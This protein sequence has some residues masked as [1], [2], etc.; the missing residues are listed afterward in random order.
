MKYKFTYILLF[1]LILFVLSFNTQK[2]QIKDQIKLLTLETEFTAGEQIEFRFS[3]ESIISPNLYISNSYGSTLL[4]PK[5]ENNL[6]IYYIPETISTKSGIV[7]WKLINEDQNLSGRF[8]IRP[9]SSVHTIESY[10]GPPSIQAGETDFSM[11]VGIPTDELD[12]PVQ[13]STLVIIKTQF[14][15]SEVNSEVYTNHL[16]A[17]KNIYSPKQT[18]RILISSVSLGTA[19]KEF[20]INVLASVPTN[21]SISEHRNH[22]YADG[23]QIVTLSTSRILDDYENVIED[24]TF[25]EFYIT[26]K[27]GAILKTSGTSINGIATAKI[28]HPDHAEKWIVKAFIKGMAES[29]EITFGFEQLF[30]VFEV[31]FSEDNRTVTVGPLKSF[32]QQLIPDGFNVSLSVYRDQYLI[33]TINKQTTAG[34]VTFKLNPDIFPEDNYIFKIR[35]AGLEKIYELKRPW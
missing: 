5:S 27:T 9:K 17:Y 13:D 23:N 2:S 15:A 26:T 6:L 3:S 10:L 33:Q 12:N 18:G 19:S 8:Y 24:G 22:N 16:I 21:F 34:N 35:T 14:L 20:D 29:D 31:I 28:I 1:G 25:V 32:M 30:D 11:I 7:N 4:L